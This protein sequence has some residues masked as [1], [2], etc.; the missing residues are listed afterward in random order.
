MA[1]V[2]GGRKN[3]VFCAHVKVFPHNDVVSS[4]HDVSWSRGC[5]Y[6][7]QIKSTDRPCRVWGFS[8]LGSVSEPTTCRM[9]VGV[10]DGGHSPYTVA[11]HRLISDLPELHMKLIK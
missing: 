6:T 3:D 1:A 2:G 7:F 10:L 4:V 8:R 5:F 9:P 11:N